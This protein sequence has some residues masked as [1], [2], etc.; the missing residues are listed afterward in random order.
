MRHEFHQFTRMDLMRFVTIRDTN[1]MNLHKLIYR[2]T[3][4]SQFR[5]N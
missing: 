3:L 4:A 2:L 1:S 5:G